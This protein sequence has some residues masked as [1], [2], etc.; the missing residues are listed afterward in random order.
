LRETPPEKNQIILIN[1]KVLL[2]EKPLDSMVEYTAGLSA[3]VWI[4][5]KAL[6]RWERRLRKLLSEGTRYP[7]TRRYTEFK[8]SVILRLGRET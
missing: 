5:N 4:M 1:D 8:D 6:A 2:D 7:R 3:A